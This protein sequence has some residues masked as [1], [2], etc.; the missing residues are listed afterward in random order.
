MTPT[1]GTP[2]AA[3]PHVKLTEDISGT[4]RP[5]GRRARPWSRAR[6]TGRVLALDVSVPCPDFPT[7]G[8]PAGLA[9]ARYLPGQP[10]SRPL[11]ATTRSTSGASLGTGTGGSK[12]PLR[13]SRSSGGYMPVMAARQASSVAGSCW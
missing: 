10:G 12:M 2:R 1:S 8:M 11:Y 9:G 13:A 4:Y 3:K 6:P 7:T 5:T